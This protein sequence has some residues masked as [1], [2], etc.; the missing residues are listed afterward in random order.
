MVKKPEEVGG[1]KVATGEL[2][3]GRGGAAAGSK[4]VGA[5]PPQAS[6]ALK[7]FAIFT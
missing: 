7:I 4:G 2:C 6:K 5:Q 3:R 1:Q